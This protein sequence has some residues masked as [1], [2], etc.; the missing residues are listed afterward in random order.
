MDYQEQVYDLQR[1]L[2]IAGFKLS[3]FLLVVGVTPATWRNWKAGRTQPQ[4]EKWKI[5]RAE[6][7]RFMSEADASA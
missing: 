1:D 3:A 6:F 7:D 5:V 4:R 2:E